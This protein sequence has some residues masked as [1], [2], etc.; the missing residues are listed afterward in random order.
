VTDAD[1]I[2][3]HRPSIGPEERAAVD[4]VLASGWLTTGPRVREF[5]AA[6]AAFVGSRHAVA[7]SSATAALH[8]ALDALGISEGDEVILPT[9]TFAASGEVVLYQRARPVLVD[10]DPR[11]LN[12][13]PDSV[14]RAVSGRTKAV[15]VVHLGGLPAQVAGIAAAA[16][17]VPIVEDAAHAFPSRMA[18]ADGRMAGTLGRAG[19]YSFYATKTITT[20]EGGMLVTDD[21]ALADRVRQMSLHGISRDAWKRYTAGGSWYYEVEAAGFKDNMTDIAAALGL[22]QLQR[23]DAMRAERARL[24]ARYL[25]MLAPQ[26]DAGRLIMPTS[27]RGDEHAWHLFIVRLGDEGGPTDPAAPGVAILPPA[28]QPLATRR[29]QVIDEL[30]AAGIGTSVHFIPLHLHPLYRSMGYGPGDFPDAERAYAGAIS[31]PIWSG[32]SDGDVGRVATALERAL[33]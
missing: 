31:L 27:G 3:F 7:L 1:A 4:A 2:P 17:G 23:A 26:A 21:D 11:T 33:A 32:M 8:L 9:Y 25:D 10:V 28:L 14:S 19:A 5:E 24:A 20:G 16:P 29:A 22:A 13:T 12:L 18:G 15:E 6:F 30:R